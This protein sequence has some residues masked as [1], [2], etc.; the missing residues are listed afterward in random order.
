MLEYNGG[1]IYDLVLSR[2][3]NSMGGGGGKKKNLDH[4]PH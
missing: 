4:P 2:G 1:K 3:S